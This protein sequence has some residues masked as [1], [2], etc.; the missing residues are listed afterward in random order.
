MTLKP[1]LMLFSHISSTQSITGAE[2]LLLS[3]C[4]QMESYFDCVLV[5]P[6]EGIIARMAREAEIRVIIQPYE[7]LHYMYIPYE[8]L[9]EDAAELM[10][11][12]S[13]QE[14]VQL[15]HEENPHLIVSNTCVNVIPVMA[16]RILGIPAIWKL[17]EIIQTNPYTAEAIQFIDE[18]SDWVIAIS[19]AVTEPLMH[20]SIPSKLTVLPPTWNEA[21]AAP[22]EWEG[23]RQTQRKTLGLTP[24]HLCIGYISSFI[25]EAKGLK[26]FI[27]SALL[28][29]ERFPHT[30]FWVIGT[31]V[32]MAYYEECISLIQQS[33]FAHQFLFTDFIEDVSCAYSAMDLAVIPSLVKE[34]FGM[35]ALE[36]MY[37]AKPVVAFQQGGLAELM[38]SVDNGHFLVAPGDTEELAAK[39]IPFITNRKESARTGQ[40]NH[41][42]AVQM[43]GPA[44]YEKRTA[45][46]VQQWVTLFPDWFS[47]LHSERN[48]LSLQAYQ[49]ANQP[50]PTKRKR[51][52]KTK[53]SSSLLLKSKPRAKGKKR[54]TAIT[55][56]KRSRTKIRVQKQRKRA[57]K[58]R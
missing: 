6:C 48:I 9:R 37:F 17:T 42:K 33:G 4:R 51:R 54:I 27:Q 31:A 30:R 1:K 34:G 22:D 39:M 12:P 13:S 21:L 11:H 56:K 57:R 24:G 45:S 43:Y 41:S 50:S 10:L 46:M 5:V 18:H 23:L 58:A 7:L 14:V 47:D 32:D 3:F 52:K 19:H 36:S 2:K 49:A 26:P 20:S 16:A 8:Q 53:R 44:A 35:T 38:E 15:L 28:L 25:Y 29:C 40:H 55:R